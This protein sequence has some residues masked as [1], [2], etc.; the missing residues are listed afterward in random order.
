VSIPQGTYCNGLSVIASGATVNFASGT[1]Y[2]SNG[3]TI[4]GSGDIFN[5][6]ACTFYINSGALS[7]TASGSTYNFTAPQSG[8]YDGILFFQNRS[9]SSSATIT[10]SG[11]NSVFEGALYFPDAPLTFTASGSSANLYLAFV[12]KSLNIT[13]SS[14]TINDY[15]ALYGTSPIGTARLA[16]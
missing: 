12:V 1:Y 4:T 2:I 14:T 5:C 9:D 8:T 3:L 16:E 6:S 11:T 15:A 10:V 7:D 13:T